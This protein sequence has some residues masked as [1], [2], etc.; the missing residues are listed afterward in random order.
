MYILKL[1]SITLYIETKKMLK[2]I[3]TDKINVTENTLFFSGVKNH[4][5]FTFNL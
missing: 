3:P 2:R 5:S 1:Y 4:H